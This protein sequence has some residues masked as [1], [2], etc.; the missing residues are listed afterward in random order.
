MRAHRLAITFAAALVATLA[1]APVASAAGTTATLPAP[2]D[3]HVVSNTAEAL[4]LAW[5]VSS[6]PGVYYELYHDNQTYPYWVSGTATIKIDRNDITGLEPGTTHTWRVR[7]GDQKG[8]FSDFSSLTVT[9]APGDVT[10]PTTPT[11]LRVVHQDETGVQLAW[12]PST[13]DSGRLFY[14]MQVSTVSL[15]L[16]DE[17]SFFLEAGNSWLGTTPGSSVAVVLHAEDHT[18]WNPS[19]SSNVITVNF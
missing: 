19:G 17:P 5:D 13:D 7:A 16:G 9:W 18:R 6:D 12:D 14:V 3:M 1:F 4:T 2:S 15:E 8:D 11:N 10:P